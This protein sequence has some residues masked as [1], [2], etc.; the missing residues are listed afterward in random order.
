MPTTLVRRAAGGEQR[1]AGAFAQDAVEVTPELE[2]AA[3]L[4][5]DTWQ[6][7][8]A[9]TTLTRDNGTAMATAFADTSKLQLD[10]RIGA[11]FHISREVAVRGSVYRAFRAPTLNELYRPFQVGTILTAANDRLRP[12]TLWGGELGT[13]LVLDGLAA[14]A[15]A[16]WNQMNDPIANVT[17]AMPVDGAARQRQNLG[18]T[19]ILGVDLDVTWR[20]AADWT[21]R[22]AH[23]F[24]D[25]YVRSAPAQPDLVGNRLAQ[26]PHH[27]TTAAVSYDNPRIATLS[28]ELRYLGP[29]F[30]DDQNTQPIGSVVLFNARAERALAHGFSVFVIGQNLSDRHYLVGRSGIDTEGAPRTFE[31][32]LAYHAGAR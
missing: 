26:D 22:V 20:P 23:T 9:S 10:P 27:R 13:Q 14:Q 5:L 6:N 25:G 16:F 12:E 15:T 4:R 19:R 2:L 31:L 11:L 21:V 28:A 7:V 1:F 3:A 32:G 29:Q 17:L 8:D 18:S 24:S 30:E